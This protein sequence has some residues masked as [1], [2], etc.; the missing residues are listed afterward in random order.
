MSDDS[1]VVSMQAFR[2]RETQPDEPVMVEH[3]ASGIWIPGD[4]KFHPAARFEFEAGERELKF[5]VAVRV[6]K[7][8]PSPFK[9][10]LVL[11]RENS[12]DAR[13]FWLSFNSKNFGRENDWY[14]YTSQTSEPMNIAENTKYILAAK[15]E[16]LDTCEL[17]I[18][19][20]ELTNCLRNPS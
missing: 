10:E 16:S 12:W 3:T 8:L 2:D 1:K 5:S 14:T 9:V 17:E 19:I 20:I 6:R 7:I 18:D 15:V 11:T 4:G 13:V